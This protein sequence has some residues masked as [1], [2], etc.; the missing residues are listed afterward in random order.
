MKWASYTSGGLDRIGVLR[1]D[2]LYAYGGCDN[3]VDLL[4]DAAT[5][6]S[7]AAAHA[8]ASPVDVTPLASA[9]LR[10]PIEK[11]P[12]IRDFMAF[13]SH[14]VTSM[15][16]LGESMDP[17]WYEIPVFYF[18]NPA[19]VVGPDARVQIAPG[20]T[21]FDYE[22]EV[23]AVLAR[24]GSDLSP[25]EAEDSIAGYTIMCDWSARDLQQ[26]EMRLGLGPSKG[27]DTATSLGP[28]LVTPDELSDAR[29]NKAFDLT[30]RASVNGRRY[31][32][33]NLADLYWS[34]GEMIAYA[35]RGTRLLPGDT[36]GSGTVGSGCIL[37]LARTYGGEQYPYL[38]EGDVVTIDV[39]R[40]G[41]LTHRIDAA[42]PIN[43][44]VRQGI[45]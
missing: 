13:E 30:M 11:P 42:R 23:A 37:E 18:T 12:S 29:K 27:K 14:V 43:A 26:R 17:Y 32:S 19:A 4:A 39:D 28:W 36:F 21:S 6:L 41:T 35:S 25:Q 1:G 44:A 2:Q 38:E 34:F 5:T 3:L 33:G 9:T 22:L 7:E 40:L 45:L 15:A 10:A 31:S 20:S 16:A 24:G 8:L